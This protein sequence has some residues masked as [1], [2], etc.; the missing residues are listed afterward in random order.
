MPFPPSTRIPPAPALVS[1]ALP[2]RVR[3]VLETVHALVFEL[4][5]DPLDRL[6][7]ELES[8]IAHL[9]D[10]GAHH[11]VA[12]STLDQM[13]LLQRR[14]GAFVAR[15]MQ[16]ID[17]ELAGLRQRRPAPAP[18]EAP[19]PAR[20]FGELRLVDEDEADEGTE[21]RAIAT[22]QESRAAL[23]LQL[24]C[25]RFA[26][27][28]ASPAFEPGRLPVGPRRLCELMLGA[29]EATGFS[30]A[31]RVALLREFDR[32]VLAEY[33]GIAEALNEA[34]A[35]RGIMPGL[36]Y[37]PLRAR[38]RAVAPEAVDATPERDRPLT[39]WTSQ[40]AP[41]VEA[42]TFQ[43]LQ[44]LLAS[45]RS[46]TDRFRGGTPAAGRPRVE[47]DTAEVVDLLADVDPAVQQQDFESVRQW[48]LL[49]ARQQHGQAVA[50]S[51]QDADTFELL[52]LLYAHL[53]RELRAGGVAV[54][55]L[56]QLR[57]PL[58]RLALGDPGF[59]V[60]AAHPGR[61]LVNAI[62][63]AGAKWQ[64][65]DGV[66]PQLVLHLQRLVEDLSRPQADMEAAFRGAVQSLD[67]QMQGLARRSEIGE[68]RHVE[69]ARGKEKLAIAR[70]R[71]TAVVGEALGDARLPTFHRNM[72]RSAWA[73]VL[74]L[75][76]L[77]YGDGHP[78]WQA[79]VDATQALVRAGSG[80]A[81]P[82]ADLQPLVEQWLATVGYHSEDAARVSRILTATERDGDDDASSR[83]ELA[84]RLKSRARLGE[85][86]LP[87]EAARPPRTPQEQA[88]YQR[89]RT[90]P[91]GTWMEF[92]DAD[93]GVSRRRLSWLSPVTGTMLFVNQRGQ[94]VADA[95]LDDVA[96]QMAAGRARIV[97]AGEGRLVDRAWRS[98]LQSL[99]G[100]ARPGNDEPAGEPE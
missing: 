97:T 26:V 15:F 51:P 29:A 77:R 24:L 50:L 61:E 22:R 12:M 99:R 49:R 17:A 62:A 47:L 35:R 93:G 38:P 52:G 46:M 69:A 9:Q 85:D 28:A 56:E 14:Q 33:P 43:L 57:L 16:D 70:S 89:L 72:L 90:L 63:E 79:L 64:G 58:L 5:V 45:R 80:A 19:A 59:F 84:M 37:V 74:T 75:G 71:S 30:L 96:R 91:F 41:E 94:R 1:A 20:G 21:L 27:L 81:P 68:R 78:E 83:T 60:R 95:T 8:R 31:L 18:V 36:S 13:Q 23:S 73:D 76:H 2:P 82:P 4:V 11:A 25:Q 42:L 48:L 66:D 10:R 7:P 53:A 54:E 32:N 55:M 86:A 3:E 92:T 40:P 88:Q 44:E 87:D 6:I 100:L 39:G 67:A 65:T 98:A 34:L